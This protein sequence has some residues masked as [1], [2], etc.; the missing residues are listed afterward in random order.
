M[1]FRENVKI[2]GKVIEIYERVI[3]TEHFKIRLIR[4]VIDE[5]FALGQKYK[6]EINEDVQILVKFLMNCLYGEQIRK[7]IEEKFACKSE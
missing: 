6:D 7:D 2:R 3:Y 4:K 5:I 1:D